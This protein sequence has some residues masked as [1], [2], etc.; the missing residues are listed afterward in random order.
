MDRDRWRAQLKY[1]AIDPHAPAAVSPKPP[2][3]WYS[4]PDEIELA[5]PACIREWHEGSWVHDRAC[6]L[7]SA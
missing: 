5:C 2:D 3:S 4:P 6:L 7:R 1:L